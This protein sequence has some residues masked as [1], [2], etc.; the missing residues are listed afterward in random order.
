MAE[1][2]ELTALEQVDVLRRRERA[3]CAARASDKQRLAKGGDNLAPLAA[4]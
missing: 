1:P 3:A 4:G 2:H